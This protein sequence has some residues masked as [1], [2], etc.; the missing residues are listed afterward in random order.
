[1]YFSKYY[2][3]VEAIVILEYVKLY[4]HMQNPLKDSLWA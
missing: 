1:M 3:I 4:N 2:R